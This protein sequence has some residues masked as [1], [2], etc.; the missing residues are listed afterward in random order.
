MAKTV[1][2]DYLSKEKSGEEGSGAWLEGF[3]KLGEQFHFDL[4]A[5]LQ[6]Q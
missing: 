2:R 3:R 6:G 4:D 1:Y 5:I